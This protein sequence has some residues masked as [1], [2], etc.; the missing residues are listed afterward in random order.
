[1]LTVGLPSGIGDFSWGYS[2]LMHEG[3]MNYEVADGWPYRTTPYV[4]MLTEVN[5]S[6]Y[7][8]FRYEDILA[9][10]HVQGIKNGSTWKGIKDQ[11][12]GKILIEPNRHLEMG[13]RLEEWLPDLP[14]NFHY[15]INIP[16]RSSKQAQEILS[17]LPRPIIGISAASYRGSEAWKTWGYEEWSPF[18]QS[19]SA[20][21]YTILLLGGYWDDLTYSLAQ[22]GYKDTVGKTSV[23][24][25][26]ALLDQIDYY[27]GFSSGLGIL[28]TVLRKNAFMMWPTHQEL[29][30]T[31]WAPQEMLE[32]GE[33]QMSLWLNWE[34]VI[35]K[36]KGWLRI[37]G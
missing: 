10:E 5:N 23:Q 3:P 16:E 4:D 34:V 33:Y 15:D 26:I 25:A 31:S 21:G 12:F 11:G 22:D 24:T 6:R 30:S 8:I 36:V 35:E 19:L 14:C 28:R 17:D 18:L 13:K 29:L 20:E 32:S 37:N 1:M 9:F 7:G 27:I 2:K